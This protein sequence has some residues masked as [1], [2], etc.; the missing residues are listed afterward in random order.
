M[1]TIHGGKTEFNQWDLDQLVTCSCLQEGDEVVFRAFGKAYETTAFVQGGEVL[2][3]VPNHLLQ[4]PGN[5]QIDLGW[6]LDCHMDCRTTIA[7]AAKDKP[8]EYE[9]PY[10]IK[11]RNNGG[12][13]VS[14]GGKTL[15]LTRNAFKLAQTTS[16]SSD[17][18]WEDVDT[19]T[20]NVNMS[21]EEVL[22]A[23]R[24]A[25][26]TNI[27]FYDTLFNFNQNKYLP[28]SCPGYIEDLSLMYGV[29]CLCVTN[30]KTDDKERY[31]YW[32]AKGLSEESPLL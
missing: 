30:D 12:S 9:C 13:N 17:P 22:A 25:E 15:I 31:V 4:K 6:G 5:I 20:T 3:D 23:Y 26:L 11:P 1:F 14:G 24:N 29:D 21:F 18:R 8:E 7:V 16:D 32:T 10:N 28:W 19:W 27:V 2:A